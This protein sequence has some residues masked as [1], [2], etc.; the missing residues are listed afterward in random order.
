MMQPSLE[1]APQPGDPL[2]A[3]NSEQSLAYSDIKLVKLTIEIYGVNHEI[4]LYIDSEKY[5]HRSILELLLQN[6]LYESETVTFITQYLQAG[7]CFVDIGAHVGYFSLLAAALVGEQGQVVAFEPEAVNYDALQQN[8]ALNGFKNITSFPCA[9][10]ETHKAS[11]LF[12]NQDNDAGHAL[13]DVALH[14]FNQKSRL[15]CTTRQ[16]EVLT[17]DSVL[18]NLRPKL[19][20]MVKIDTEGSEFN[21]LQGAIRTILT[22]NIPYIICE[23]NRFGLEKMGASEKT[24]RDYLSAFGYEAYLLNDLGYRVHDT[25]PNLIKLAP[26]TFVETNYVFNIIFANVDIPTR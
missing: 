6:K 26:Q 15:A 23:I 19:V 10:G 5:A 18:E 9:L 25:T 17:L 20:K 12:I 24:L 11:Q 7:D 21:I 22:C 13:W 3:I 4:S 8:I 2:L 14:P 1:A 16:V